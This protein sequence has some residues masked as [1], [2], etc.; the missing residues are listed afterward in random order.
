MTNGTT[1]LAVLGLGTMGRGMAGS[2]LRAGIPTVVWNREPEVSRA[3]AD[4]GAE[5][6]LTAADA[7]RAA[8][9]AITMVTDARAVMSIA[10][11]LGMLEALPP[12]AVWAQ[13]S[14]IGAEATD[15]IASTVGERRPDISF[16]DAPVS[17]SKVPAE[18][19][20]LTIFASGPDEARRKVEPVFAAI[21]ERTVWVGPVG[22][23]SRIKLV[24]NTL[25]AFSAEGVASSLAL[26][27]R[28]GLETARILDA[29]Q[30]GPLISPW[31]AGKF[32]RIGDGD[33]SP[34]FPL[35]L[36]LKDVHLALEHGG[37]ERFVVLACLSR[38]WEQIVAQGHGDEDVTVVTRV[39]EGS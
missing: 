11:D 1:R 31:E 15:R 30:G 3:F 4:R 13:M 2:A 17:G 39:L 14:T 29:F 21:G 36:A 25:L 10:V 27:R 22:T 7:V 37:P 38:E 5:I 24:N 20:T 34:E 18:Q 19:G 23:G 33:Y 28:L 6:A 32:R 9:V 8:D 35:A 12:G 16:L 26:A